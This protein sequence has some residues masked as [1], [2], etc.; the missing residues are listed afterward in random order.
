MGTIYQPICHSC[1]HNYNNISEGFGM[2]TPYSNIIP[3]PCYP[4]KRLTTI[5]ANKEE[6][7]CSRCKREVQPFE[8]FLSEDEDVFIDDLKFKCPKCGE[9]ELQFWNVGLWD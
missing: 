6:M 5:D 9:K 4:C 8:A 1:N 2:L 3:T 7:I